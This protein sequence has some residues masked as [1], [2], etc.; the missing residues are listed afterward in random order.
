MISA[1][2]WEISQGKIISVNW[3][4]CYRF[5]IYIYFKILKRLKCNIF[6]DKNCV[7]NFFKMRSLTVIC[8]GT[9]TGDK[10]ILEG[11]SNSNKDSRGRLREDTKVFINGLT[12]T[13]EKENVCVFL[14][15]VVQG[16]I[17]TPLMAR[18]LKNRLFFHYRKAVN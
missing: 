16:V 10:P 8:E 5:F 15:L 18:T 9:L 3:L 4:L 1:H 17:S 11:S 2:I 13:V 12:T 6:Q 7:T 14:P